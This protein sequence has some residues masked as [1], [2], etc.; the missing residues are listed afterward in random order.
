[1]TASPN[2]P[3][4]PPG[5][6]ALPDFHPDDTSS[7][8]AGGKPSSRKW[9][10]VLTLVLLSA[11]LGFLLWRVLGGSGQEEGQGPQAVPV[12]MER[13][14]EDSLQDSSEFVG[15]LDSQAGVS[16]QPEADGRVVQIFVSS[17]DSVQAGDP[18]YAAER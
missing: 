14:Q 18:D 8:E 3:P 2:T 12:Q 13:L 4:L 9:L 7:T 11:G 16:L 10:W 6:T 1:M 15:T 17:G 5:T